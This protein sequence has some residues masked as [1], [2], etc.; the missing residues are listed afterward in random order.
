MVSTTALLLLILH[1][2][3]AQEQG[4]AAPPSDT[5][6]QGKN[7]ERQETYIPKDLEDCF[8]ELNRLLSKDLIET[9]RTGA[10][11]DM[12]YYHHGL[13]TWIRNN[14][15]L[16]KGSRLSRWFNE[17]GIHRP[18]DMS[19]IIFDSFWRHLN[20]Q[21]IHLEQQIKTYERENLGV[22]I[23]TGVRKF[24]IAGEQVEIPWW[25]V[26]A[27]YNSIRTA[28]FWKK[29]RSLPGSRAVYV[30][31]YCEMKWCEL[32]NDGS[33]DNLAAWGVDFLIGAEENR[34]RVEPGPGEVMIRRW[35]FEE[36]GQ[37]PSM[38]FKD[39]RYY[40]FCCERDPVEQWRT[41]S[42]KPACDLDTE[43]DYVTDIIEIEP[44]F[45][46]DDSSSSLLHVTPESLR[47]FRQERSSRGTGYEQEIAIVRDRDGTFRCE[48]KDVARAAVKSEV[49]QKLLYAINTCKWTKQSEPQ[50]GEV[51]PAVIRTVI[52]FVDDDGELRRVVISYGQGGWYMKHFDS[53]HYSTT[54]PQLLF[55]VKA[56]IRAAC[57][58]RQ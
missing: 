26:P 8:V 38:A 46:L 19:G 49:I 4:G 34:H 17:K 36:Q 12:I 50:G 25:R 24:T 31:R 14:W 55:E 42:N 9:M 2:S 56:D 20:A 16:W 47:A 22:P 39:G 48:A 52:T 43:L 21:P 37:S 10:E 58:A 11:E 1:A 5:L 23:R 45:E 33:T 6:E 54:Y 32:L 7:R 51:A 40:V 57:A 29:V 27:D 3:A 41:A 44:T 30:G 35:Q 53:G 18:D 28:E 15:G 13:G